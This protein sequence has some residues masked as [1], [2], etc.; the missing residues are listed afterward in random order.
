MLMT[1]C[2]CRTYESSAFDSYAEPVERTVVG[3]WCAAGVYYG[4]LIGAA[5]GATVTLVG[6]LWFVAYLGVLVGGVVGSAV[7]SAVGL[8]VGAANGMALTLLAA[9]RAWDVSPRQQARRSACTAVST[10]I[11]TVVCLQLALFRS[12]T[13]QGVLVFLDLPMVLGAVAAAYLTS[14]LPP[15][16]R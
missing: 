7:G 3:A 16:V 10:T 2:P 5:F 9:S 15:E 8:A 11:F 4:A 12:V 6:G 13:D 14:R 1:R